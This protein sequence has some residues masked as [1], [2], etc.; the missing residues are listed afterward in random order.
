MIMIWVRETTPCSKIPGDGQ[1]RRLQ[2]RVESEACKTHPTTQMLYKNTSDRLSWHLATAKDF[3]YFTQVSSKTDKLVHRTYIPDAQ[4]STAEL[5][6]ATL[7]IQFIQSSVLLSL[8]K[9]MTHR[10]KQVLPTQFQS[11]SHRDKFPLSHSFCLLYSRE[12]MS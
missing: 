6:S 12:S 8:P 11:L 3:C 4:K 2:S 1:N 5:L 9:I 7:Q 10:I